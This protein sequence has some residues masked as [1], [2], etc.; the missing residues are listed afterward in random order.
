MKQ[1]IGALR[2]LKV[3]IIRVSSDL[4]NVELLGNFDA[5]RKIQGILKKQRSG[6]SHGSLLCEV[7]FQ[8]I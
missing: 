3:S 1:Q 8:P 5:R 7:H 6:K 4:E 2:F